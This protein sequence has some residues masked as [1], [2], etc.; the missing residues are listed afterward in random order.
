MNTHIKNPLV[1]AVVE[2]VS[3]NA[4]S[5]LGHHTFD[6]KDIVCGQTFVAPSEGEL[7]AIEVFASIVTTPGNVVMTVHSFDPQLKSWGPVLGSASVGFTRTDTGTWKSFNVPGLHLNKGKM[8]G[9][10]LATQDCY[11]GVGEA[12]GS[13]ERPISIGGQEWKFVNKDQQGQSFSYFSLAFK[14]AVRA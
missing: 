1:K 8:Y 7:E 10:R 5:W 6:N 14:V 11:I 3:N 9:F 13:C 4:T 2:Q 12:V